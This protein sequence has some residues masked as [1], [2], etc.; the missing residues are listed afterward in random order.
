MTQTHTNQLAIVY[1]GTLET[2]RNATAENSRFT[3]LFRAF[4]HVGIDAVP[5]VYHDDL[6][7]EVRQQLLGCAAALIWVNPIEGGRDRSR[8]D[9][10]LREVARSGVFVST[11][12]DVI[13]LLGTKEVLHRTRDIGWGCDTHLYLNGED[14]RRELPLRLATGRARVL[15]RNRGNGGH[16][17]WRVQ[18]ADRGPDGAME[19]G[20]HGIPGMDR[21]ISVRHAA[22]GSREE[23]MTIRDFCDRCDVYFSAVDGRIID[24]EFQERIAEGMVRCYL[25]HDRVAGFGHQAVNALVPAPDDSP[26]DAPPEPGPRLYHPPARHEFQSV[27]RKLEDEWIPAVRRLLD[28]ERETLPVLWDCDF[29]LGPKGPGGEDTHVLCEINVSSVAPFPDSVVPAM[30]DA[31]LERLGMRGSHH[32]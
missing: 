20:S 5:A 7:D 14:L 15:K 18:L 9:A 11:H 31:M 24:Q 27:K 2:R 13:Q 1:P 32:G 17:V 21:W 25:V 10:L 3:G 22:R 30:L 6:V 19:T 26:L 28:L 4:A 8:L 16:G 12:P 23:V 29:L